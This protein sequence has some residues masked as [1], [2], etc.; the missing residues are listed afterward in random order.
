M[1]RG[2]ARIIFSKNKLPELRQDTH[3]ECGHTCA[4]MI[5]N[6]H[7]HLIDLISLREI[8]TPPDNGINLLALMKLLEKLKLQSRAIKIELME[9]SQIKS[10]AILH[11]DLNHFVVLKSMNSRYLIIHDPAQGRRKIPIKEASASF[12]GVVLEIEPSTDFSRLSTTKTLGIF[13][14]FKQIPGIIKTLLVLFML[15]LSIEF[16]ALLNP[17]FIQYVSDNLLTSLNL[18]N[19]YI[20]A[21][22]FAILTSCHAFIDYV[23]S[24]LAV[25]LSNTVSE[26]LASNLVSHILKLPLSYFEKRHRGDI[27]SRFQSLPEL[28]KKITT[29]SI[30]NLLDG[31]F[32]IIN[33]VVMLIY[34]RLLTFIVLITLALYLGLRLL[35]YPYLKNQ[36]EE[37]IR[38][39]AHENSKFLELLNSMMPIKIFVKEGAIHSLWKNHFIKALNADVRLAKLSILYQSSTLLLFNIEP[40]VIICL[41]AQL[42]LSNHFSIGMLIAFLAYR[43]QFM[44]KSSGLIQRLIDFKLIA[45]QLNRLSDILLH[46]IEEEKN[47]PIVHKQ[48]TGSLRLENLSFQ[49]TAHQQAIFKNINLE[50]HA[51]EKLVITGPSGIG[52]T[53]LLKVM[54]GLLDKTEGEIYLDQI[55]LSLLGKKSYRAIT[56]SVMQSDSLISGSILDNISFLDLTIDLDRLYFAT[57]AAQIHSTIINLPM[58]YETLIGDMGSILSG[59]QKQRLLLAR[60]LYKQPKILFLDEASSHLDTETEQKINLAL[61]KM[62]ITQIVIAHRQETIDMADRV[63][64]IGKEPA[65]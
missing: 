45:I 25:Y 17:L 7:G 52:K 32:I 26:Q 43:Q 47:L 29:D 61:K 39:H 22:G 13:D 33:L 63:I 53:T 10:P 9:L 15:S 3:S 56:S 42:A 31:L 48:L 28:Q 50:I 16:L 27:L 19:L 46:P 30:N 24:H 14:L 20:V 8:D 59:G 6:Y 64:N 44:T 60:A 51:G 11:W 41:G 1:T 35:S 23:R 62:D 40:I 49:Y 18:N 57:E 65:L 4:A 36:T 34:S 54:M 21:L 58:G 37:S 55:P 5:A 12:T 2:F 38:E